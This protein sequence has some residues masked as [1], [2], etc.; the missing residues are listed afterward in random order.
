MWNSHGVVISWNERSKQWYFK[1][2]CVSTAHTYHNVYKHVTWTAGVSST[3][4]TC[5]F[6]QYCVST[7]VHFSCTWH[8]TLWILNHNT[9]CTFFIFLI[10]FYFFNFFLFK[11][12]ACL[13]MCI[14]FYFYFVFLHVFAYTFKSRVHCGSTFRRFRGTLLLYLHLCAFLQYLTR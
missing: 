13:H 5:G 1:I 8:T 11:S 10:F 12:V 2:E 14:L 3:R 7:C 4:V 6:P 9:H